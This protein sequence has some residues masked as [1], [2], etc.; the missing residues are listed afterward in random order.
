MEIK[1]PISQRLGNIF[2]WFMMMLILVITILI[3]GYFAQPY[4]FDTSCAG[5]A[6]SNTFN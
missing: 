2:E 4:L 6:I 3:I 1:T 5:L